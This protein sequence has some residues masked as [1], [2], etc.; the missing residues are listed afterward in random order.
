MKPRPIWVVVDE[1][2]RPTISGSVIPYG[3]GRT[4]KEAIEEAEYANDWQDVSARG[5]RCVRYEAVGK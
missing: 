2:G 3:I 5:Y 4:R 1:R